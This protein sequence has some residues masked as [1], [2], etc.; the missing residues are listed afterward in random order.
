MIDI[1]YLIANKDTIAPLHLL[2]CQSHPHE[3]PA[4]HKQRLLIHGLI[5]GTM[6]YMGNNMQL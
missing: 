5:L 3:L 2:L 4:A 6:D 1:C